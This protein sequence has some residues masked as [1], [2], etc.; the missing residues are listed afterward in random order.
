[1][2]LG[3]VPYLPKVDLSPPSSSSSSSSSYF[4][5]IF[6]YCLNV[7][8]LTFTIK[9]IKVLPELFRA[10]RFC[11]DGGLREFITWK[12]GTLVSI[13]RQVGVSLVVLILSTC[14][15]FSFLLCVR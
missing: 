7:M 13:V 6:F 4:I 15:F 5:F 12:L 1:M 14:L 11:E 9:F 3:C 2:G 8:N 10:V